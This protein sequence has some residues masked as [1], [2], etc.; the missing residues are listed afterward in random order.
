VEALAEALADERTAAAAQRALVTI[1]E[2]TRDEVTAD[3]AVETLAGAL[4]DKRTAA[5]AQR[6]LVII[7]GASKNAAAAE[8]AAERLTDH[9]EGTLAD[10]DLAP[11]ALET[12]GDLEAE[13]S[14]DV[15]EGA[16]ADPALADSAELSLRRLKRSQKEAVATRAGQ[17]L[18]AIDTGGPELLPRQPPP[19]R[20]QSRSAE[21]DKSHFLVV[22]ERLTGGRV[23]PFLGAGANLVDRGEQA[24]EP[25]RP[26]LPS[27]A[28]LARFLAHR[29]GYPLTGE[30]DLSRV[31]Q[32]VSMELGEGPLYRDLHEVFSAAYAPTSLHR[33][34][35]RVA[36]ALGE[37]GLPQLVVATT[38]Y[39]DL[40]EQAFTE[41]GL[42]FDVV[43]YEAKPT[44]KSS[45]R[46]VHLAPGGKPTLIERPNKYSGLSSM[47]ERPA[48]VKLRGSFKRESPDDDSYVITEDSYIDYLRGGLEPM[49]PIPVLQR[50]TANALLFVGYSISAWNRRLVLNEIWG[51]R[52]RGQT[53]WAVQREPADP[54]ESRIEQA[55]WNTRDTDLIYS[56]LGDYVKQ[57][58]ASLGDAAR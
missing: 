10:P 54:S 57:L 27:E 23:I 52:R 26:F 9:L 40:V 6:A 34:F 4:A 19:P 3:L 13:R 30:H 56:D 48:I 7:G 41:Q 58:E 18:E 47:L 45:G 35:A 51:D 33:L 49:L 29:V 55:M 15:L 16:L 44:Q 21:V 8:L 43:W 20:K 28:E 17:A 42:E 22:A 24:W 39:D 50:L 2:A 31:S 46:F 32:Y 14:V 12:L 37:A 11:F 36:K 5:G 1:A 25:G 53:S 38:N